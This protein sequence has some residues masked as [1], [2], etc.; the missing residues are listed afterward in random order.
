MKYIQSCKLKGINRL[1]EGFF[2]VPFLISFCLLSFSFSHFFVLST[3]GPFFFKDQLMAMA[4]IHVEEL[5]WIYLHFVC[6]VLFCFANYM[7][8]LLKLLPT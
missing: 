7:S 1:G 6:F 4:H 8:E 2:S 5:Y 3:K